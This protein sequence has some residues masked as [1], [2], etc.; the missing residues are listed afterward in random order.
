[1]RAKYGDQ[2]I[3]DIEA[4]AAKAKPWSE[5]KKARV[6]QILALSRTNRSA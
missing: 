1:M 3:A 6:R 2:F 5:A 4:S